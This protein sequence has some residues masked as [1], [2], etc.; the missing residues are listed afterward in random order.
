MGV[1]LE[2]EVA[3]EDVRARSGL[4]KFP[5]PVTDPE[6]LG[7]AQLPD[8]ARGSGPRSPP[9]GPAGPGNH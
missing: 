8:G 9:L 3:E 7:P 5:L 2:D 1:G 6:A 4:G